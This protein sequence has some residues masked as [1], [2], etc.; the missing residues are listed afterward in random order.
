MASFTEKA[1]LDV[2]DKSTGD[3][4]K[5]NRELNNLFRTASK[6]QRLSGRPFININTR[7]LT[8][9]NRQLQ[10]FTRNVNAARAAAA[11][12]ITVTTR[13]SAFSTGGA[14][15]W[16]RTAAT[17]FGTALGI[18]AAAIGRKI[19]QSIATGGRA[20]DIAEN[21]LGLL[22]MT[23]TER[24]DVGRAIEQIISEQRALPQGPT[25]NRHQIEQIMA[26]ALPSTVTEAGEFNADAAKFMIDQVNSLI[27]LQIAT[28]VAAKDAVGRAQ[29]FIKAGFASGRLTDTA[30]GVFSPE[31]AI[32]FFNTLRKLAPAVGQEF[33][34]EFVRTMLRNFPTMKF[35]VSDEALA[36]ILL[37]GEEERTKIVTGLET[38]GN[39][40]F[41]TI[42]RAGSETGKALREAGFRTEDMGAVS[43]KQREFQRDP[44]SVVDEIVRFMRGRGLDPTKPEDVTAATKQLAITSRASGAL[45]TLVIQA[46]ELANQ[47]ESMS[48]NT[49]TVEE[50]QQRTANSIVLAG[51]KLSSSFEGMAGQAVRVIEPMMRPVMQ[52]MTDI[53]TSTADAIAKGEAPD[54]SK[55][56]A[57]VT[58]AAPQLLATGA[59]LKA[60][61]ATGVLQGVGLTAG[62]A[63]LMNPA[64]A[65]LAAAGLSLSSAAVD[66]SS[67]ATALTGAAAAGGIANTFFGK[68]K[69]LLRFLP[70]AAG[71][72][73]TVASLIPSAAKKVEEVHGEPTFDPRNI[74]KAIVDAINRSE[75]KLGVVPD[76]IQQF[77]ERKRQ[78]ERDD[79]ERVFRFKLY[80]DLR[81]EEG[82]PK[83][84]PKTDRLSEAA[85]SMIDPARFGA[86]AARPIDL[87]FTQGVG[88]LYTVS[89]D[90]AS[91]ITTSSGIA[92]I[93]ISTA[94]TGAAP[95]I[96]TTIAGAFQALAPSIGSVIG[97]SAAAQ[98]N[99]A[100]VNVNINAPA[101]DT[102]AQLPVQ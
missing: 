99:A 100:R 84:T 91:S 10:A 72:L 86:E 50:V 69:G 52:S 82:I 93:N 24:T 53:F 67:A 94:M 30:T 34:G 85:T 92:G 37:V 7:Q 83:T 20:Q 31:K 101:A 73:A 35:S 11:R 3:I 66:L 27:E 25:L 49:G 26:E 77:Q 29:D 1:V 36:K 22:G 60:L 5:I 4:R 21:R 90:I 89:T 18:T 42:R 65:P 15:M 6:L 57:D 74:G 9:A 75:P 13:R 102:G 2:V 46:Q 59:A 79:I 61:A 78:E 40:L 76:Q 71:I 54:Y 81:R 33:T 68:G 51:A 39:A 58:K 55:V 70:G 96:G 23:P 62:I 80:E 48:R 47:F 38:A 97:Q 56:I 95:T 87:A 32:E 12:P 45:A 28:G 64:T 41:T 44:F 88:T 16:G 17:A 43:E 8:Q 14:Q 19:G 98:I 63:G